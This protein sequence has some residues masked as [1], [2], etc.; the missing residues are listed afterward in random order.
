MPQSAEA[1]A[2]D[3]TTFRRVLGCFATGVTIV[4]SIEEDGTLCGL[5]A[6]SF[7]SVSL[8]P[9]L[10]LVCLDARSNSLG[11]IRH[12]GAFAVNI[13]GEG[14]RDLSGRFASKLPDKFVEG[15]WSRAVTGSPT[16]DGALAWL[17][18]RVERALTAGDHEIVGG[19]GAMLVHALNLAGIAVKSAAIGMK[20]EFGRSAYSARELY[21]HFGMGP[22]D[23][24]EAVRKLCR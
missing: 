2:F 18:C 19:M 13:L 21:D 17:D 10:V 4:T 5:T 23:I 16:L 3:R 15:K 8:D 24:A 14:Q 20:G 7:T 1:P 22:G 9:P 11:A 12:S 6:N